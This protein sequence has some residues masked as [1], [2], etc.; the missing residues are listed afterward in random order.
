MRC[1]NP[2]RKGICKSAGGY[3]FVFRRVVYR[4]KEADE[5]SRGKGL[6][7]KDEISLKTAVGKFI[8]FTQTDAGH[9]ALYKQ[10]QNSCNW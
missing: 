9:I 7:K 10:K 4:T 6:N 5:S 1:N 8:L 3:G 2:S